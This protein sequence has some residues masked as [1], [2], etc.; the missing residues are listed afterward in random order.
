MAAYRTEQRYVLHKGREFH[1][2]SYEGQP[3]DPRKSLAATPPSWYLINAGKRWAVIPQIADES[4]EEIHR[5][6]VEWLETNVFS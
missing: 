1:F 4:E 2:A 3:A 5:R 6:L